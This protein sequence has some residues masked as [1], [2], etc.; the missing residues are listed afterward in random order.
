M[1]C[2]SA[3]FCHWCWVCQT[4]YLGNCWSLSHMM[5]TSMS[6]GRHCEKWGTL[7]SGSVENYGGQWHLNR[8]YTCDT[9]QQ[10]MRKTLSDLWQRDIKQMWG[11][12]ST[13]LCGDATL[14][15]DPCRSQVS[16]YYIHVFMGPCIGQSWERWSIKKLWNPNNL[17]ASVQLRFLLHDQRHFI[18]FLNVGNSATSTPVTVR[19]QTAG[20][21]AVWVGQVWMSLLGTG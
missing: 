5:S 2:F 20:E 19:Y 3:F 15:R 6:E 4:L 13:A 9:G 10:S 17:H 21:A 12:R 7:K 8:L 1:T 18:L 14:I 11:Q 16:C